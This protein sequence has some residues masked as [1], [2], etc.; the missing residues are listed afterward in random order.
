MNHLV[1][2]PGMM[3]DHRLWRHQIDAL[4][5]GHRITVPSIAKDNSIR[6]IAHAVLSEAPLEFALAGLSMG[7]IVAFEMFRQAPQRITKLA[8]LDT[9]FLAD[10]EAKQAVRD[11][12]IQRVTDGELYAVLRDE[13]KP[14]YLAQIHRSNDEMLNEVLDMGLSLGSAAFIR[15][16]TALRNRADSTDTLS[17]INVDTLVLCGAEDELCPPT[18]HDAMSQRI[19]RASLVVLGDCGHLSAL[20]QPDQVSHALQQ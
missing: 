5:S 4:E 11:Q 8:L 10:T 16:A 20:E 1:L 18:L 13:L 19:P 15:Q 12:Q 9:N 14:N 2:L 6:D 17:H 3:C 7:G